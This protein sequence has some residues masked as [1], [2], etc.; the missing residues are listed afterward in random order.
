[1]CK[2]I[3]MR[4]DVKYMVICLSWSTVKVKTEN[5][6]VKSEKM[7]PVN[8]KKLQLVLNLTICDEI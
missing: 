1:M 4:N 7:V 6:P 2:T 3:E 5:D 8:N